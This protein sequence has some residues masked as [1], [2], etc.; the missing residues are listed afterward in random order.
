MEQKLDLTNNNQKIFAGILIAATLIALYFLLP[1][2]VFLFKNL[3]L[4]AIYSVPI[5][6][7]IL[8]PMLVW[9]VYKQIS[10]A[11]TKWLVAS[12]KLGYMYR[13]HD[14][15]LLKIGKLEENVKSVGAIKI[16]L[17]R[18]IS[19]LKET[20]DNDSR[21]VAN[22]QERKASDLVIRSAANR[23]KV[24]TD[25]MNSLLP[26]AVNVENQE[27]YLQQLYDAWS[28]DAVDLKYVLDSKA[29]EFKLLKEINSAT[30]NASEFL[31]GNSE[32]Y[33]IYQ[34]S[35]NQIEQSVTQYTSNIE[36]FERKVNPILES[37]NA[38][39]SVS[40]DAGLKLI[41]DWKQNNS[42]NFKKIAA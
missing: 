1:P 28:A 34:E 20:I 8:N 5:I 4:L 41:E 3:W 7:I 13:Y 21:Q 18:K 19:E 30:G 27:K 39:R 24:A 36:N 16:R 40:E 17:Q 14:Y 32:E 38:N 2:L 22:L 29:E 26:K 31:K 33:K 15:L 35:L 25:Q 11:M 6:F 12:D 42:T 9:N 23:V 10:W 37:L